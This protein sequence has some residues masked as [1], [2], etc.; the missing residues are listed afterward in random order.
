MASKQRDNTKV[1]KTYEKLLP[2]K[3]TE[4]DKLDRGMRL[5]EAEESLQQLLEEKKAN[6]AHW[7]AEEKKIEAEMSKLALAIRQGHEP[8]TVTCEVIA[9]YSQ[10]KIRHVRLDTREILEDETR[11]LRDHEKQEDLIP[12]EKTA[13]APKPDP[14]K[15]PTMEEVE[16]QKDDGEEPWEE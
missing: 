4:K 11:D 2:V 3:L 10:R 8:K 12:S 13:A 9:D 16:E 14:K 7:S 5:A 15:R 1:L 6:A